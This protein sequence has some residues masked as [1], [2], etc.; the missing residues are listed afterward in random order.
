[1]KAILIDDEP[2]ALEFLEHQLNKT[3]SCQIVGKYIDP[4]KGREAVERQ[5]V[6]IVFLDIGHPEIDGMELA[7]R[8]LEHRPGIQ[9]VFVTSYDEYAVRA[10]E[11][12]AID[13]LVK[14][15]REERLLNT[16][17]RLERNAKTR[18]EQ[19]IANTGEWKIRL[20]GDVS[21]TRDNGEPIS[22]RWRTAKAQQLF[23]YLLKSRGSVVGKSE[24]IE[25][26]WPDVEP[27]RAFPQLYTTVYH[28]RKTLEELRGRV[29]LQNENNGYALKLKHIELDVDVVEHFLRFGQPISEENVREHERLVNLFQDTYLPG[30]DYPWAENERQRYQLQWL[31]MKM[32]LVK[33]Y[34]A[35]NRWEEA[36][37]HC[38]QLC[39]RFPLEEEVHFTFM[40]ICDKLG[41]V[42]L[43]QKAYA[44][45]ESALEKEL[46][47][48]PG[49]E[50]TQW[51]TQWKMRRKSMQGLMTHDER[52]G[53]QEMD[54]DHFDFFD[55]HY[56]R[57]VD[58]AGGSEGVRVPREGRR[59]SGDRGFA[60]MDVYGSSDV[61]TGRRVGILPCR[62]DRSRGKYRS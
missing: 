10:F 24:I 31:H 52:R 37:R 56:R 22:L 43:V 11:L 41:L 8:L 30:N 16:L 34:S 42:L 27:S 36:F 14:P 26:L 40:K 13:Y 9:V 21:I 62:A 45:L 61:E 44:L 6:D 12:N 28:I 7:E 58:L 51:Y 3:G 17:K 57:P 32:E 50:I 55:R 46:G 39:H 29:L 19:T 23:Q 54:R 5:D 35:Q 60:R 33:W 49:S 15:V 53:G 18:S 48:Q 1:M 2:L 38:E 20:F 47:E 59:R 4:L 25:W